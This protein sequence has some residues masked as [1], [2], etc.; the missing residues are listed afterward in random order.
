MVRGIYTAAM[1]MLID[2]EKL[3][4]ISN[5]LANVESV[6]YKKDVPIFKTYL[7]KGIYAMN[8]KGMTYPLWKVGRL[9]H[10]IIVDRVYFSMK[11]GDMVETDE[12]F[13]FAIDGEGFFTVMGKDGEILYTRAGNF[14]LDND[15]YL[16]TNEGLKVLDDEG[17][18][19]LWKEDY[20]VD[21][22]GWVHDGEGKRIFRF[23]IV[24]FDDPKGLEKVGYSLFR[25]SER[26]GKPE[27]ISKGRMKILRG[28]LES[29]N[30][31]VFK[32]MINMINALRHFEIS[33]RVIVT[34]DQL[35]DRAVNSVGGMRG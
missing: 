27:K 9:E 2:Q 12:K 30:V 6:G 7:M 28:Y 23:G 10:A 35:L 5:N 19:I 17:N 4:S 13:D 14:K 1:G 24:G 34:E 16:R 18:P 15:G 21:E 11:Q 32:E 22:E 33:Q 26:S 20:T 8:K 29:S 3:N 31:Q 25:E